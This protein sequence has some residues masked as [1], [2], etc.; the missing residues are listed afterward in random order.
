MWKIWLTNWVEDWVDKFYRKI[1]WTNWVDKL[2]G[3]CDEKV[4]L[5]NWVEIVLFSLWRES[6]CS[7]VWGREPFARLL[8]D[9]TPPEEVNEQLLG[10]SKWSEI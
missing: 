1:G 5:E 10:K 3:K 4:W 2:S 8:L 9:L 6:Q 7:S